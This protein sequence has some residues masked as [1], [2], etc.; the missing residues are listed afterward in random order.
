[1]AGAAVAAIRATARKIFFIASLLEFAGRRAS[2]MR[3][4]GMNEI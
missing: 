3:P 2:V 4:N 1:M